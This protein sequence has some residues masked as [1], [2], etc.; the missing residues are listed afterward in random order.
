MGARDMLFGMAPH[1]SHVRLLPGWPL[2]L[3]PSLFNAPHHRHTQQ[4][5]LYLAMLPLSSH[6][7]LPC[8]GSSPKCSPKLPCHGFEIW[9]AGALSPILR[10]KRV[11]ALQPHKQLSPSFFPP[12]TCKAPRPL[13]LTPSLLPP[14]A[15]PLCL[16]PFLSPPLNRSRPPL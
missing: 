12:H 3:V 6:P 10:P 16:A 8:R 7:S 15:C 5:M 13:S 1:R 2:H 14:L 4:H 9:P 11:R